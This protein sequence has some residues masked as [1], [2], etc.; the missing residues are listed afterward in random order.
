M[1]VC[2]CVIETLSFYNWI[3]KK[4]NSEENNKW[5]DGGRAGGGRGLAATS[6]ARNPQLVTDESMDGRMLCIAVRRMV[7]SSSQFE[8]AASVG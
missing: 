7:T 5:E 3:R 2:V 4:I 8:S 6:S 1:T